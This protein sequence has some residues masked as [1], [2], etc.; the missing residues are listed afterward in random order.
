MSTTAPATTPHEA[1]MLEEIKADNLQ[2]DQRARELIQAIASDTR[3]RE[4]IARDWLQLYDGNQGLLRHT[5]GELRSALQAGPGISRREAA[6]YI[7]AGL[8]AS[9]T[10]ATARRVVADRL[11]ILDELAPL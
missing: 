4:R 11:A 2:D 10:A 3:V 1:A 9:T 5:M 7:L 6:V 8:A